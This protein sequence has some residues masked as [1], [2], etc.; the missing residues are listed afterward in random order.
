MS[1]FRSR[2]SRKVATALGTLERA[3]IGCLGTLYKT[4]TD[5]FVLPLAN[6]EKFGPLHYLVRGA[7]H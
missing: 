5:A 7:E 1:F 3:V 4:V 2:Y 6:T